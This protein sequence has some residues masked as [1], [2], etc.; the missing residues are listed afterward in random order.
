MA[1]ARRELLALGAVAVAAGVAGA[2]FGAFGTQSQSGAAELLAERFSDL[3]GKPVRLRDSR[4]RAL[5]CN[6]WATWCEPCR[7]E[8]PLLVAAQQQYAAQGLE[9]VGIGIDQAAKLQQF[10]EQ[11][12]ISY[13]VFVA[14][15]DT[16]RLLSA[17]GNRAS[18]LPFSVLLDRNRRIV[19]RKLGIWHKEELEREIRSAIG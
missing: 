10:A 17:L 12:R 3:S 18:A 2:L 15:G 7:E 16:T 11:Y 4:A 13:P 8:V 5:L 14:A 9:V 1:L 6:F 19:Q